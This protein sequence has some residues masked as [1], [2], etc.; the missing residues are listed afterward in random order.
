MSAD[1]I[2]RPEPAAERPPASP[3]GD[4]SGRELG[5]DSGRELGRDSG[6]DSG[7]PP[8]E[9]GDALMLFVAALLL[10]VVVGSLTQ[11]YRP[12]PAGVALTELIA[13]LL[14]ALLWSRARR[15]R[16][17]SFLGLDLGR[18]VA[19]G[20]GVS[21]VSGARGLLWGVAGGLLCGVSWFYVVAAWLEPLAE[22]VVPVSPSERQ[23]LM[24]LLLP[25]SG[26]RPLWLDLLCFAAVPALCEEVLFR[27][28]ILQSLLVPARQPLPGARSRALTALS[29]VGCALLFGAFHLSWAKLLPTGILGLGF[30]AVAVWSGSLWPAI[31]MHF[32]NNALVILLMRLGYE[33]PPAAARSFSASG[34]L[35]GTGAVL[36]G[37][38]GV[39]LLRRGRGDARDPARDDAQARP[40]TP[41]GPADA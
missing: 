1:P 9:P 14:P 41:A 23:H 35:L 25:A 8:G 33:E 11:R 27:G 38:A 34:L 36:A 3:A 15:Q 26:L 2:R 6:R 39:W 12:G 28:A 5:R 20:P 29:V 18:R 22:R 30:G 37:L 7:G 31:V 13:I 17:L 21:G 10:L 40:G 19:A 16:V 4:D 24:Q 32:T